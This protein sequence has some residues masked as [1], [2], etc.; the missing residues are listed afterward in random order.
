MG[1]ARETSSPS[2]TTLPSWTRSEPPCSET[3]R[4][5]SLP[6]EAPR[7][8]TGLTTVW[9]LCW[10]E[11]SSR[12][13]RFTRTENSKTTRRKKRTTKE[14]KERTSFP[15]DSNVPPKEKKRKQKTPQNNISTLEKKDNNKSQ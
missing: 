8:C 4:R 12:W 11:R 3:R 10:A 1:L 2:W 7:K 6:S 14:T 5:C 15:T 13:I 9:P